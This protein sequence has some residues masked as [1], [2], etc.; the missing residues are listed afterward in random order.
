MNSFGISYTNTYR[1]NR[2][3]VVNWAFRSVLHRLRGLR[4]RCRLRGGL[5]GELRYE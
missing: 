5:M 2:F 3:Y 4:E 1:Y